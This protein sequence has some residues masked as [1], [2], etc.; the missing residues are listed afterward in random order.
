MHEGPKDEWYGFAFEWRFLRAERVRRARKDYAC[1][2]VFI[3]SD[4]IPTWPATGG[5]VLEGF[6]PS[7]TGRILPRD[8]YVDLT[9][10]GGDAP[11]T[12]GTY[13]HTYHTCIR[14]ALH[15]EV[16]ADRQLRELIST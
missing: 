10:E 15:L 2:G 5:A 8:F 9:K 7:C 14:C 4:L 12:H 3:D 11:E 1:D 16:V 6:A 13:R